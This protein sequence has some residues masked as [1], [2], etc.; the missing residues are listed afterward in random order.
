M[1]TLEL[2]SKKNFEISIE[3]VFLSKKE[4]ICK[5]GFFLRINYII[6]ATL[7]K[8]ILCQKSQTELRKSSLTN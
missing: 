7:L 5:K 3:I 8:N 1:F 2:I 6:F 4:A